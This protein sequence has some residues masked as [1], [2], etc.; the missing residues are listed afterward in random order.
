MRNLY[1]RV[2]LD[3]PGNEA[4]PS[5]TAISTTLLN[6][7]LHFMYFCDCNNMNFTIFKSDLNASYML[8]PCHVKTSNI[9]MRKLRNSLQMA[10]ILKL[11]F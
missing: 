10:L 4:T 6:F 7:D 5:F 8:N 3:Q 1:L 2:D 9:A 11:T